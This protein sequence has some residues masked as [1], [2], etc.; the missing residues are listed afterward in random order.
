MLPKIRYD[1]TDIS[2]VK[3]YKYDT[4][5]H[6]LTALGAFPKGM[7]LRFF[8]TCPRRLGATAVVLRLNRDGE[9]T[10]TRR[11]N[12]LVRILQADLTALS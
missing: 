2:R 9:D 12:S 1:D 5:G 8:V 3:F 11:L 10:P 6:E 7:T 4:G